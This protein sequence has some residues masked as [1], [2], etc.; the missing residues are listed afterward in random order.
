MIIII[1]LI[2][3]CIINVILLNNLPFTYQ[4]LSF[5]TPMFLITIIPIINYYLKNKKVYFLI[6][7]FLALIHDLLASE[8]FLLTFVTILI[9]AFI[10]YLYYTKKTFNLKNLIFTT[11]ISLIIYDCLIFFTLNIMCNYTYQINDL[12]YK[13][14]H[15]LIIN[16]FLITILYVLVL[17]SRIKT[18]TNH[19][20]L[21]K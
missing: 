14:S 15:S 17:K 13:I 1:F 16:I 3:T 6:I 11:I 20:K 21:K 7:S 5:F 10:N 8:I 9:I 12:L 19:P 2:I 18:H 4:N